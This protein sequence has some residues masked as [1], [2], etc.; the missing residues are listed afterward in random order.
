ML[1]REG[2]GELYSVNAADTVAAHGGV[3]P[4]PRG[5]ADAAAQRARCDAVAR[6]FETDD[7]HP[8]VYTLLGNELARCW[9]PTRDRAG[10]RTGSRSG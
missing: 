10:P 6:L 1:L 2:R 7:P 9:T 8:D 3:P 5:D 4:R